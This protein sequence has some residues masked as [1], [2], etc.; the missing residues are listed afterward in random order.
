MPLSSSSMSPPSSI[1]CKV[2]ESQDLHFVTVLM[3][4]VTEQHDG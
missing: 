1:N 3:I 4:P 2:R